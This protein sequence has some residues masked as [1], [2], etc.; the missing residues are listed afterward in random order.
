MI[1]QQVHGEIAAKGSVAVAAIATDASDLDRALIELDVV[2]LM[3]VGCGIGAGDRNVDRRVDS[4]VEVDDTSREMAVA[5]G[6]GAVATCRDYVGA[7]QAQHGG[8]G[9]GAS[10]NCD[11]AASAVPSDTGH[12]KSG[13]IELD[14]VRLIGMGTGIVSRH[15]DVDWVIQR[16]GR[17]NEA[18]VKVSVSAV[19]GVVIPAH[20]HIGAGPTVVGRVACP[21]VGMAGCGSLGERH[22]A[23]NRCIAVAAM[24]APAGS[25]ERA[26][27]K[28]HCIQ[29][30]SVSCAM[31][32]RHGNV[33]RV[34]DR[35]RS[36]HECS[37]EMAIS[38]IA[39][40]VVTGRDHV[41]ADRTE[42]ANA[43]ANCDIA[44]SAVTASP[45]YLFRSLIKNPDIRLMS[46]GRR[47]RARLRHIERLERS[48]AAVD[49]TAVKIAVAAIAGAVASRLD[50]EERPG[51]R[52]RP[53]RNRRLAPEQ[54]FP[55]EVKAVRYMP[56]IHGRC[57][58]EIDVAPTRR[59]LA[60][61]KKECHLGKRKAESSIRIGAFGR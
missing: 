9:T 23:A 5:A 46:V 21:R 51:I 2:G 20:D 29:L 28:L 4:Y 58:T 13:L 11:I 35:D 53:R 36:M 60:D 22:A 17:V 7:D 31:E 15:R 52:G 61:L 1:C 3:R 48:V 47:M 18:A 44:A 42:R 57:P 38:T 59:T 34:V 39:G 32:A 43:S 30:M 25:L 14:I 41:G 37:V 12:L 54:S 19:T 49:Q 40:T 55:I 10:A 8:V 16:E 50:Q 56:N 26:L 33:D 45:G 24:T 27:R 6:A